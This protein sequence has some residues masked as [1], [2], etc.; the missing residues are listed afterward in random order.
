MTK[1]ITAKRGNAISLIY[2]IH[3]IYVEYLGT[4]NFNADYLIRKIKKMSRKKGL[5][6][7]SVNVFWIHSKPIFLHSFLKWDDS[8]RLSRNFEIMVTRSEFRKLFATEQR[9]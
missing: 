3:F 8:F 2:P 7:V 1:K 6:V 9:F 4:E 5:Y